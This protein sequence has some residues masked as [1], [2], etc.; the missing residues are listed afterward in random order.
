MTFRNYLISKKSEI[1][2]LKYRKLNNP[3]VIALILVESYY[4]KPLFRVIEYLY[5]II[6][7]SN[8]MTLGLS[9]MRARYIKT[10]KNLNMMQ[11]VKYVIKLESYINNY[12]LVESYLNK[13]KK[14]DFN[15]DYS[16][17]KYYNGTNSSKHYIRSFKEA[18]LYIKIIQE[19]S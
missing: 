12:F 14:L 2:L 8:E 5:W 11:R 18:K 9:Q 1:Y 19:R 10:L 4:R 3:N 17:C 16:I 13:N 7:G 6:S 15:D